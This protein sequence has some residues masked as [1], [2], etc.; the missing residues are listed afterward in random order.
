[1]SNEITAYF[2]GRAG[3][4]E[5]LY[6]YDYG[7]VLNLDGIELPSSFECYFDTTGSDEAI[8]AI[9]TD[10]RVAI[11]NDCL[12]RPGDVT[13]HIPLHSGV[14]DSQVEYV[15]KFRV[16]GRA[17]PVDGGTP[18]QQTA[19]EQALALLQNPITNIEQIVNEALA[20][21]GDTFDEMQE[22]LDADQAAYESSMNSRA[23]EFESGINNRQS[24]FE[25]GI[26]TRQATVE[27]QFTNLA[28]SLT[29]NSKEVLWTGQTLD[30]TMTLSKAI[31]NFDF[32]DIEYEQS[33][34]GAVD[35]KTITK[36]IPAIAGNY[37]VNDFTL[38]YTNKVLN[39]YEQKI[40]LSN[41]SL[42]AAQN[43]NVEAVG[44]SDAWVKQRGVYQFT[45]VRVVGIKM[46]SASPA[47][48]TDIR[49]GA[50]G[51]TYATAGEAVR[52]QFNNLTDVYYSTPATAADLAVNGEVTLPFKQGYY[53][54]TNSGTLEKDAD[55]SNPSW[56]C[57]EKIPVIPDAKYTFYYEPGDVAATGGWL[58]NVYYKD[59]TFEN[60]STQ[61]SYA[62]FDS[63]VAYFT[64][65]KRY[66]ASHESLR[67][68]C[69][70]DNRE[71]IESN[72]ATLQDKTNKLEKNKVIRYGDK[73][74]PTMQGGK[75]L[76]SDGSVVS[77]ST[78]SYTVSEPIEVEE[79]DIYIISTLGMYGN[80]C[81]AAY[82]ENDHLVFIMTNADVPE[83]PSGYHYLNDYVFTVPE[84]ATYMRIADYQDNIKLNVFGG[85]VDSDHDEIKQNVTAV[86]ASSEENLIDVTPA[87]VY[88][89]LISGGRIIDYSSTTWNGTELLDVVPGEKYVVNSW[90][91]YTNGMIAALDENESVIDVV[92]VS[93]AEAEPD[94][95]YH[96]NDYVY[97]I[98]SGAAYLFLGVYTGNGYTYSLTKKAGLAFTPKQDAV[99][100]IVNDILN[101]KEIGNTELISIATSDK[102]GFFGN[103]YMNGY[104]IRTHHVFDNLSMWSDY[105]FY[106]YGKSGDDVLET[107]M[108]INDNQTFLG[109]VPV[110]DWGITY[111]VLAMH[112]NDGALFAANPETFYQN[113]KK[114]CE[115][116]RAMGGTPILGTEH[117]MSQMYYGAQHLAE[118]EGYDFWDWGRTAS[119]M[120][121]FTPF[122]QNMHPATRTHW[123]WTYG[124]KNY[125]DALPR[126]MKSIKLFRKRP[127]TA[128]TLEALK[129]NDLIER[130]KRF[131]EIYNG[132]ACLTKATEKYFDR[133]N[134]GIAT[135]ENI[136]SE[137]QKLQSSSGSVSF[138]THALIECVTPFVKS[139]ISSLEMHL[140]ASGVTNAYLR[141]ILSLETPL[142]DSRYVAFG[143]TAGAEL[144]THGTQFTVTGGVFND[145]VLGTY[146]V[147]QVV[148]GV[149]VTTASSTGK[150]TSGTDNPVIDLSGVTLKGS[151]DYP[152]ADYMLRYEKPLCEW[153]E[154]T[155]GSEG[156]T[157]LSDY[158]DEHMDYD[159]ISIL[160]VGSSIS[161]SNVYFNVSGSKKKHTERVKKVKT[162]K[163]GTS[164]L[165]D[166]LL[167]DGT[168]WNNIASVPKY[169]PVVS[170]VDNVT[171]DPLPTG[172]T[173]VRELQEGE[174]I[175][176][177]LITTNL[178]KD[179]YHVDK[180]Q[181]RIIARYFP[182]YVN[183]DTAW[184]S[185][186]IYEGSYDCAEMSI[187]ID[188]N[189]KCAV[190][191]VGA[192][193]NEFIFDLDYLNQTATKRLKI[194]CEKKS[195]QIAK[196][197][198]VLL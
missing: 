92:D 75:L 44:G 183:S 192:S 83:E 171:V 104:T 157:D 114:V 58:L 14:N 132:S 34:T 95:Y 8:P 166:N 36:R 123:S 78:Q 65:T 178:G 135:Y 188:G 69:S 110:Q 198:M 55:P 17:R 45:I 122:M 66:D 115:A 120:K 161:I 33:G 99:E 98:P 86:M 196:A 79:G 147:D 144:L 42:T 25:S 87:L 186:E 93:K 90:M 134:N 28:T 138:D 181:V 124:M 117:Q 39:F 175:W 43:Y 7:M 128:S 103:S 184:E 16:I 85:Y 125:I 74:T 143:V 160:L 37:V 15:V 70:L 130:S 107:L 11:P 168:A 32:I 38:D 131:V 68:V 159:K 150:T 48:L 35:D 108:R 61:G 91:W 54:S 129:F 47:E 101:H 167:D 3:V 64:Y 12:S 57:V 72:I 1:M 164:L 139:S 121:W 113:C 51:K 163:N 18:E 102:I 59:G 88:G 190:A 195:L 67:I 169:T 193:W 155:L 41:T 82:D 30:G 142:P 5:S 105:L 71:A 141:R 112:A 177:N 146:T 180:V 46:G 13:L 76:Q 63:D 109:T 49:V 31:S 136:N 22:Q 197:E 140:N 170:A 153:D 176:Q 152:S 189:V 20:F 151:Y 6:Q 174:S 165:T 4:S 52:G 149:V 9:G 119:A 21:T 194:T 172:V 24:T 10:G 118:E 19:I 62:Q 173:T 29:P 111:G 185:T 191:Q 179:P 27:S 158:L 73:L 60:K 100:D 2:K 89:K 80:A 26:S 137:Y 148:N 40:T 53:F 106:N 162:R 127:D 145:N 50:N 187:C 94:N 156:V 116:I 154:I 77:F 182:L 133:L 97:T 96:L 23:T 84:N 81:F 56:Q 126:P